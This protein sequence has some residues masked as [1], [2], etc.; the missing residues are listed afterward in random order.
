[1]DWNDELV[2]A[3]TLTGRTVVITGAGSGL[4]REAARIFA[5]AG[6]DLV[7]ADINEAGLA[8]TEGLIAAAGGRSVL[9]RIDVSVPAQ[10]DALADAAVAQWGRLDV[11]VNGAGVSYLHALTDTAPDKAAKVVAVNMMGPYWG[12]VSAA[13][14]MCE[15]GGGAIINISSGGGAKPLPGIGL[16]GM[17]KAAVNS[18][19]WT[20]AAEFGA[21]GIRVNAVAPGWIETPMSRDL[22]RDET[23]RISEERKHQVREQMRQNAM[24]KVLGRPS[25]IAYAL[26]Y[27]AS[28]ASRFVT[29]Q[30]LAVN[31]GE[32]M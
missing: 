18:L 19:T 25:D 28:D 9:R 21:M 6:A 11:W 8:E 32:S 12:S 20:S 17:T 10:L 30:I 13:R 29:G 22:F 3:F 31:G 26:L 14:V 27:L 23:G 15:R 5:L 2:G 1:M 4:G 16:Y 7:L 24:L